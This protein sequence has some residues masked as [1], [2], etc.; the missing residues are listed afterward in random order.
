MDYVV[1]PGVLLVTNT[2]AL[3]VFVPA[4]NIILKTYCMLRFQKR[5]VCA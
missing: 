3:I 1:S 4:Y 2:E 5:Y